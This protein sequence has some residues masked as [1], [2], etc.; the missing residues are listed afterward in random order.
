[1]ISYRLCLCRPCSVMTNPSLHSGTEWGK[2]R[3]FVFAH[4]QKTSE[5][6]SCF[7]PNSQT[8]KDGGGEAHETVPLRTSV[9][10]DNFLLFVVKNGSAFEKTTLEHRNLSLRC[11]IGQPSSV[12]RRAVKTSIDCLLFHAR[13]RFRCEIDSECFDS[14]NQVSI[15][16]IHH[17]SSNLLLYQ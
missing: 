3:V 1:M 5:P 7:L 10:R 14:Q 17:H 16:P 6:D 11:P 13:T 9:F 4:K 12:Q 15:T 8:A 2:G